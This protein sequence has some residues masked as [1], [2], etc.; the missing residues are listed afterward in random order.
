[1]S[2]APDTRLG[3]HGIADRIGVGRMEEVYQATDTTRPLSPGGV[4]VGQDEQLGAKCEARVP[5]RRLAR[6]DVLNGPLVFLASFASSYVAGFELRVG[7]GFT[8]G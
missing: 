5:L 8:A 6:P 1:M 3:P 4:L 7:G 2:L